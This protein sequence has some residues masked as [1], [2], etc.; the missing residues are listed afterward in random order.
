VSLREQPHL[1]AKP[2]HGVPFTIKTPSMEDNLKHQVG[3]RQ[4]MK[5]A[6]PSFP[7]YELEPSAPRTWQNNLQAVASV[8][9][10]LFL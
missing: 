1:A 10:K 8:V 4:E 6:D 2:V 3:N 5:H 7:A 9:T